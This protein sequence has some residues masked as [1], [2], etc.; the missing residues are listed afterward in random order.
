[1]ASNAN[2]TLFTSCFRYLQYLDMSYN[3]IQ[4]VT[5]LDNLNIRELNLEGNCITSFKSAHGGN[6][7]HDL[8]IINLS[9][10]KLTTLK[11]FKVIIESLLPLK[12]AILP[13]IYLNRYNRTFVGCIQ[14]TLYGS[15]I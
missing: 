9:Y 13:G 14:F 5:N 7:L 11:F 12:T 3:F 10:N 6:M 15:K 4:C 1:M 8:R 2:W